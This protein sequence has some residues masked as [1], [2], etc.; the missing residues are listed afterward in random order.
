MPADLALEARDLT[1][2]FGGLVA[3]DE[4]SVGIPANQI[5]GVIGPNGAGKTTLFNAICGFVRPRSGD[6]TYRGSSLIGVKT[7]QLTSV[8]ISRTLQG[9]GLWPG[10][11]VTENVMVG[12]LRRRRPHFVTAL[13]GLPRSDLDEAAVR[14]TAT[15]IL[16]ELGIAQ[17]GDALPSSLPYGVQKWVAMAR[18]LVSRPSLLLLDEPASGLGAGE[19]EQFVTRLQGWR[20]EMTIVLVEHRL[21]LVMSACD[22]VT[23]LDFGQV[24]A[25]GTPAAIQS[26]PAVTAAY[27]GE[28]LDSADA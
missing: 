20:S 5:T 8:G 6:I 25:S 23:V 4:V 17:Y 22:Q 21:D 18:A 15:G 12:A 16:E 13:L 14:A 11:T 27:L 7:S 24:I 9:L 26:N 10:L 1:V 19:I 2:S 3:L 28:D